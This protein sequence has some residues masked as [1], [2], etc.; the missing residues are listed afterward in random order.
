MNS[1]HHPH[2]HEHHHDVHQQRLL[3]F[4][5]FCNQRS[6]GSSSSSSCSSSS[7]SSG[8]SSSNRRNKS[9][10]RRHQKQAN[11]TNRNKF[12]IQYQQQLLQQQKQS[13]NVFGCDL[14]QHTNLFSQDDS[15]PHIVKSCTRFIEKHGIIFG[16]YRLSGMRVNIHKLRQEFDKNPKI[17]MID[18]EAISNDAHAVACVLKQYFRELPTPLLT[19]HMYEKFIELFKQSNNNQTKQQQTITNT[20]RANPLKKLDKDKSKIIHHLHHHN[21]KANHS[22][23][24]DNITNA[25]SNYGITTTRDNINNNNSNN[26]IDNDNK[27]T[28]ITTRTTTTTTSSDNANTNKEITADSTSTPMTTKSKSTTLH[29][30]SSAIETSNNNNNKSNINNNNQAKQFTTSASDS[31]LISLSSVVTTTTT[32][33]KYQ[34]KL[35]D[36]RKLLLQLPKAHYQTLKFLMRHLACIAAN[37][38]K[39]GMDSKNVAI[40]WAPNLLKPRELELSAGLE[41]LQII[42]LQA[43]ITE[44]LIKHHEFLFNEDEKA[45]TATSMQTNDKLIREQEEDVEAKGVSDDDRMKIDRLNRDCNDDISQKNQPKQPVPVHNNQEQTIPESIENEK[46]QEKFE[47]KFRDENEE[48]KF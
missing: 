17:S 7:S 39:T 44:Q 16:I 19:F 26:N 41:T 27:T 15:I 29:I 34:V 13:S 46:Q 31:Q 37:G 23:D 14:I 38:Q 9:S 12:A 8:G 36:L 43:V 35:E 3:W 10:T 4:F 21:Q 18:S 33:V 1:P 11:T 20:I 40:V 28:L 48:N 30:T 22:V 32:D 45:S 2:H 5:S 6:S 24:H 25:S 47:N 42:G